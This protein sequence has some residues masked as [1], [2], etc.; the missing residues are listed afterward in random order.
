MNPKYPSKNLYNEIEINDDINL[1]NYIDEY[2]EYDDY[3]DLYNLVK[4]A[5][6][7]SIISKVWD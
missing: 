5:Y 3:N 1:E 4:D 7:D 6:R 2:D